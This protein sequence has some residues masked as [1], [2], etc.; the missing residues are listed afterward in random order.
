MLSGHWELSG[1]HSSRGS[2]ESGYTPTISV[3]L[4]PS[5]ADFCMPPPSIPAALHLSGVYLLKSEPIK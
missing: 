4:C 5:C 2:L 1:A 3:S